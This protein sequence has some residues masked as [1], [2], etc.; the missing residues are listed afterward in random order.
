[1][2]DKI[3]KIV[4]LGGGT[5]GWMSAA[6]I[7]KLVGSSVWVELVESEQIG[8]IGVGEATIPPIKLFN[9]ALG[10]SEAELI[11]ETKATIKLAIKFENWKTIGDSYYHT[12][13]AA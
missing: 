7:Q 4:I 5:A 13:G 9:S 12:F 3:R 6:L 2:K 8:T 10:I 11:R 1:M